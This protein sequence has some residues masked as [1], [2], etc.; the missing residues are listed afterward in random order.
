MVNSTLSRNFAAGG[1]GANAGIGLGGAIVNLNGAVTVESSTLAEN[2]APAG[3]GA[4]TNLGYDGATV[5]SAAVTIH[6]SI[7]SGTTPALVADLLVSA[8]PSVS[9][10]LANMSV[11]N[12]SA[13]DHDLVQ[14][15]VASGA[16]V[17]SGA[18]LTADPQ[19]GALAGNGGL[20]QT[21]LPAPGS[22]VADAGGVSGCPAT[23]ERGVARPQGP[24]CDIG[25]VELAVAAPPL[26]GPV[27]APILTGVSESAR[28][29]RENN[30][31]AVLT[32]TKRKRPPVGTRFSF[33]LNESATVKLSFTQRLAG[34]KV[35][36][37]C[38]VQGAKNRHKPRCTCTVIV[39]TLT[40]A[41]HEGVNK[42]RFAGRISA[43]KKL[44][45]GRYSLQITAT[46]AQGKRSGPKSLSFTIVK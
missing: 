35:H 20:T 9:G 40:F 37:R 25:A 11:A 3:G 6:R 2:S 42:V 26:L 15:S 28:T 1:T 19:L 45:L 33:I 4:I 36:G 32:A 21:R 22:P 13:S 24:A 14:T 29:W 8:P 27:L 44:K 17:I 23:D 31:L 12:V 46:S 16:A 10:A 43:R 38:A 5:R 41:A 18:P 39:G 34:R 30:T 7:L